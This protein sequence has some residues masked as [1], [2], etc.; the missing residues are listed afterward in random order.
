MTN[1]LVSFQFRKISSAEQ[2]QKYLN[3]PL[4]KSQLSYKVVNEML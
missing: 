1:Q 4:S 2:A 3:I